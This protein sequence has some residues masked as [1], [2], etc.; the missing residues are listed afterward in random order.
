MRSIGSVRC[1][2]RARGAITTYTNLVS[3]AELPDHQAFSRCG[4]PLIVFVAYLCV[5][6]CIL[7]C[8]CADGTGVS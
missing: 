8:V 2:G 6:V 1:G 5:S 3:N 4:T 7:V